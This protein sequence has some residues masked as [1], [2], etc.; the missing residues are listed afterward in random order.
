MKKI[1]FVK[2]SFYFLDLVSEYQQ[3]Q[4]APR[5]EDGEEGYDDAY[6]EEVES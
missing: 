4:D 3:H 2:Y 5:E 1:L 6:D